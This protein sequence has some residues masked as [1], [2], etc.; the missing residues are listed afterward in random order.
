MLQQPCPQILIGNNNFKKNS[1]IYN[2]NLYGSFLL[3]GIWFLN[4]SAI[5]FEPD[6]IPLKG[7]SLASGPNCATLLLPDQPPGTKPTSGLEGRWIL[8]KAWLQMTFIVGFTFATQKCW[9][10]LYSGVVFCN[11]SEVVAHSR[12]SRGEFCCQTVRRRSTCRFSPRPVAVSH[13]ASS[14]ERTYL[15]GW[16][17][18]SATVLTTHCSST[19]PL[20]LNKPE[21]VDPP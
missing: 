8:P 21:G 16:S 4:S 12:S 7:R 1:I 17:S 20:K 15:W 11:I 3:L 6:L 2:F 13:S 5:L 18:S 10:L 9:S 14:P 19:A